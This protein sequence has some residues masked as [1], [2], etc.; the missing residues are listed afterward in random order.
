[1]QNTTYRPL[2]WTKLSQC[3]YHISFNWAHF[4][5]TRANA[6]LN[7]ENQIKKVD[8]IVSGF[9]KDL[10]SDGPIPDEPNAIQAHTQ[11]IQVSYETL[12]Y[13]N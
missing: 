4:F 8:G 5:V 10:S 6:S 9:E 2:L 1:M 11:E 3:I 7:L 13:T 12:H